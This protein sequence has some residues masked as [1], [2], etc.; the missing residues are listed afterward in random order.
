M[1]ATLSDQARPAPMRTVRVTQRTVRLTGIALAAGSLAWAAT[2]FLVGPISSS[3]LGTAIG[4]LGGLAFQIPLYAL[5]FVQERTLAT[6]VGRAWPIVFLVER[7]LLSLA[8]VWSVLHAFWPELPFLPV[9]DTFWPVSM[10]GMFCIGVA[11]AIKGRWSGP[12]RFWPLIAESWAVVCIPALAL[13]GPFVYSWL[14]GTHLL[15]GYVALGVLL[16]LAPQRTGALA[17]DTGA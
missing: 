13:A 7:I 5:L 17:A 1:S 3:P 14:P 15:V 4:D 10:I 16:A 8:V 9:L 2:L 12:L 6:G 11:I